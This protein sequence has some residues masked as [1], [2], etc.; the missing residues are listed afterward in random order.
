ME[1]KLEGF[2]GLFRCVKRVLAGTCQNLLVQYEVLSVFHGQS[3]NT[4]LQ[5]PDLVG[6]SSLWRVATPGLSS[7][8]IG[9]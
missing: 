6:V 3:D 9:T 2:R 1:Y 5:G 8:K 7:E 4:K